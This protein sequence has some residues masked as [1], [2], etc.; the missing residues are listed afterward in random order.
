M[1]LSVPM[2]IKDERADRERWLEWARNCMWTFTSYYKYTFCFRTT[3]RLLLLPGGEPEDIVATLSAGGDSG[4]IYRYEVGTEPVTWTEATACGNP[5]LYVCKPD[6]SHV[7][8][9]DYH[10]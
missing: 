7:F 6:L 10:A 2:G 9:A 8:S 5:C 4:D 1:T 3:D